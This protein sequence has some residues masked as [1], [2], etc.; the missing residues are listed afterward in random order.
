MDDVVIGDH[1]FILE[2]LSTE[3]QPLLVRKGAFSDLNSALDVADCVMPLHVV[4]VLL[5]NV[6]TNIVNIDLR[7]P[8][9][10]RTVSTCSDG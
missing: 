10:L 5:F 7:C 2:R 6:F 4:I 1:P 3:S 8:P 9:W